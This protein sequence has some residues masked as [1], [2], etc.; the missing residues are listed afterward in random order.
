M[1]PLILNWTGFF[2]VLILL[3]PLHL[4]VELP[5][6]ISTTISRVLLVALIISLGITAV[7]FP[8]SQDPARFERICI[9]MNAFS[10]LFCLQS[11][12]CDCTTL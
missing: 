12:A 6:R 8:Y 3:S 1:I 10:F 2:T 11:Q 4:L 5:S 9:V 7:A